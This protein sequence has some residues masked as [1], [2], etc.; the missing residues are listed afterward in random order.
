MFLNDIVIRS[1]CLQFFF[2]EPLACDLSGLPVIHYD[3]D[4]LDQANEGKK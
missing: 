2:T 1:L 4:E 3:E